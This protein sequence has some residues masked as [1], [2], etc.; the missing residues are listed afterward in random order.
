MAIALAGGSIPAQAGSSGAGRAAVAEASQQ[1][2]DGRPAF[3]IR[4]GL[5]SPPLPLPGWSGQLHPDYGFEIHAG[6]TGA[7]AR[8]S[9][10][11]GYSTGDFIYSPTLY[12]GSHSCIE[13]YDNYHDGLELWVWDQ[14]DVTGGLH[15]LTDIDSTFR[16]KYAPNSAYDFQIVKTNA[17]TNEWMAS[18]YNVTTSTWDVLYTTHGN[19]GGDTFGWA[20]FEAYTGYNPVTTVG[21]YC[22][23]SRGHVWKASGIKVQISGSW[24]DLGP[25]NSHWR[26]LNTPDDA[27]GC[28]SVT[29]VRDAANGYTVTNPTLSCEVTY[30]ASGWSGGFTANIT[31]KNTGPAPVNKWTLNWDFAGNQTITSTWNGITTQT[32]QHVAINNESYNAIINP[33]ATVNFGFQ[34][35]YTGTNTNPTNFTLTNGSPCT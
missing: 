22:T 5:Q 8:H 12:P 16:S 19:R 20:I 34:A 6:V 35:G 32:G 11:P 27:Y 14:C 26:G 13:L 28:P 4:P 31:L 3:T 29:A 17:A 7:R 30:S 10:N 9:I 33:G 2:A 23:K 18:V 24:V 15:K 1:A 25:S 21:D